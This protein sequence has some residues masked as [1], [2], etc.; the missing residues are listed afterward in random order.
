MTSG[1]LL[2]VFGAKY[3]FLA[4]P[5]A[6]FLYFLK[7]PASEKK[8]L[9]FLSVIALPLAYAVSRALGYFYYL[10]RPFV[11]GNFIPLVPHGPDNG[12]PS[13]HTLF[14]AAIS[15]V[16]YISDR[17]TGTALWLLTV[18][19]GLSRVLT[20]VHHFTDIYGAMA[21]SAASVW[22]AHFECRKSPKPLFPP[23]SWKL[24]RTA[25]SVPK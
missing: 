22:L 13:E 8:H 19:V 15:A 9:L 14:C 4:I 23:S 18:L 12:F 10:P 25:P 3:L 11:L 7:Q 24:R 20:G 21:I 6:A 16:I 17:K 5:A 1:D 2:I